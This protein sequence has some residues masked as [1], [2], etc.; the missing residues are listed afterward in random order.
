MTWNYDKNRHTL[1]VPTSELEKAL[2]FRSEPGVSYRI[3]R[4]VAFIA[5]VLFVIGSIAAYGWL[6]ALGVFDSQDHLLSAITSRHPSDNT[7]VFDRDGNKI[8]EYFDQYHV[9]VPYEEIPEML[10]KAI[11]AIEDRS[12]FQHP[13]IDLKGILRASM[14]VIRGGSYNQGASTITQ[15]LVRNLLLSREKTIDRK[16]KEVALSLQLEKRLSKEK[17]I[18]A[19]CN[20]MFLGNGAYGVGAA[21]QRY[22][23]RNLNELKTHELALLAGLFQ[24]PS[25]FNPKKSPELAQK[26][27]RMVIGAM[28][29]SRFITRKDT[30]RLL[31]EPLVYAEYIPI[32]ASLAPYFVDH[33]R[34][35]TDDLAGSSSVENR[36]WRIYTTLDSTLQK[37]A[38]ETPKEMDDHFFRSEKWLNRPVVKRRFAGPELPKHELELGLVSVDPRTGEVLSMLGGRDYRISQFNRAT[39]S[40]RSPGSGFKPVVYSLALDSG[41]KWSDVYFVSPVSVNGY[42]PK[43]YDDEFLTETTMLRAFFRSMNTIAVEMGSD[44]GI[45]AIIDHAIKLGVRSNLK[46]EPATILGSSEVT[47]L[48]LSRLYSSIANQGK[49]VDTIAIRKIT[50]RGGATVY[51][52]PSVEART[53]HALTPQIAYLMTDA[54]RNVFRH[55]TANAF[56]DWGDFAAGKTGTSNDSEDN[57]FNGFTPDLVTIVWSGNDDHITMNRPASGATI[58]LPIWTHYMEKVK[59]VRKFDRFRIPSGVS[60]VKI[61]PVYGYRST[62]G[63]SAYFLRGTEPRRSSSELERKPE[64]TGESFRDLY[65]H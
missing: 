1:E 4:A 58:A 39:T 41:K 54:M 3:F 12:F 20:A 14:S 31:R 22:F 30:I 21:A 59:Q 55:G 36:G 18:E 61:D 62:G 24:S 7:I 56:S 27:Q 17:I 35:L 46:V 57:W 60:S 16:V 8:G 37:I 9:Y 40:L 33:V 34:E 43:N 23:G 44:L 6:S 11:V 38:N 42:R 5:G 29:Q 2:R 15:Q 25:R 51:E 49:L 50:T 28:Y 63:V 65:S 53:T 32:N 10:V 13:G 47:M 52:A 45:P 48:D 19:Y 26:R 64:D